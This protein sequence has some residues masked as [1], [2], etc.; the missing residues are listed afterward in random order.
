MTIYLQF[1]EYLLVFGCRPIPSNWAA[2]QLLVSHRKLQFHLG[3]RDD[4]HR[5]ASQPLHNFPTTRNKR[6]FFLSGQPA[7]EMN[8]T[9]KR[10][11]CV[12]HSRT[13]GFGGET[14]CLPTCQ[15][16]RKN[17][18]TPSTPFLKN[19][20]GNRSP[21][22]LVYSITPTSPSLPHLRVPT[23]NLASAKHVQDEAAVGRAGRQAV[24]PEQG[25]RGAARLAQVDRGA[26]LM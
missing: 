1:T 21:L 2:P 13:S 15:Q 6:L 7:K 20:H 19:R 17:T 23:P 14:S 16:P 8:R 10:R 5:A 12:A 9:W 18:T 24:V 4:D 25:V 22:H 26:V 3:S 11:A